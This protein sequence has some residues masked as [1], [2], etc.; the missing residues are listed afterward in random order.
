[1]SK[2]Q[3]KRPWGKAALIALVIS[4]VMA[5]AADTIFKTPLGAHGVTVLWI[6]L[7]VAL[8]FTMKQE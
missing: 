4:I 3:P 7:T 1:M 5:V 8:A 6:I 2:Q